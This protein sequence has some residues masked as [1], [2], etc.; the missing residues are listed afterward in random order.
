MASGPCSRE[1][2]K[3]L[4]TPSKIANALDWKKQIGG[5]IATIDVHADRIGLSISHHPSSSS[6]EDESTSSLSLSLS[7]SSSSLSSST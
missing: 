1:L 5:S 3:V 6:G 7:S 2:M 4:T